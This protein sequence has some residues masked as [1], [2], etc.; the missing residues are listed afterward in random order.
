MMSYDEEI[1]YNEMI[2]NNSKALIDVALDTA[3]G[4]C[5]GADVIFDFSKTLSMSSEKKKISKYSVSSTSVMG[6]RVIKEGRVGISY[7]ESL[8]EKSIQEMALSAISNSRFS[9]SKE[10]EKISIEGEN[11]V[12]NIEYNMPKEESPSLETL[13]EKSIDLEKRVLEKDPLVISTP[14]NGI[15][16]VQGGRLI[17]NSL[18]S[19]FESFFR[20]YGAYT[21]ALIQKEGVNSSFHHSVVG[22]KYSDLVFENCIDIAYEESRSFLDA[23]PLPTKKYDV[24]FSIEMLHQIFS[25][26]TLM[27]SGMGAM[28]GHN[29]FREKI[30]ETVFDSGITITDNPLYTSGLGYSVFDAEGEK[31]KPLVLVEKGN[32][33][34]FLHNSRTANHFNLE[35]TGHASR[36][37]KSN[38]GV[39]KTNFFIEKGDV[40]HEDLFNNEVLFITNLQGLHSGAKAVS[41]DFSFGAKG[42]FF[43]D[44]EKVSSVKGITISG[45]FYQ[46][47]NQI[48]GIGDKIEGSDLSFFSPHIR[49]AD[50]SVA[51]S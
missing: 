6:I 2:K 24:I 11:I 35:S 26:F 18:D 42:H 37:A 25:C 14:Y 15:Y 31:R 30:G 19:S 9:N 1:S 47:L 43:K 21:S 16:K 4:K 51:G 46:M 22:K 8:D 7:S 41:G 50:L 33:K 3:Q 10:D 13:R 49:F 45:N 34:S 23:K 36:S 32:L 29:P 38:L 28:E 17:K 40:D 44:S 20:Y 5:Q 27:F 48:S 12:E 39:G